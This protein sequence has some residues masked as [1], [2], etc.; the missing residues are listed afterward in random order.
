[1]L[2]DLW[3]ETVLWWSSVT[4]GFAFLL[5]LPFLV[6]VAGLLGDWYR[7]SRRSKRIGATATFS[8]A[9]REMW[10]SDIWHADSR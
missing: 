7:R 3:S 9:D 4:P 5:A 10:R 1:M 2:S 8:Q 6:A